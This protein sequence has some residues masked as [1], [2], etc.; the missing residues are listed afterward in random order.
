[1]SGLCARRVISVLWGLFLLINVDLELTVIMKVQVLKM[2]VK[3][4]RSDFTALLLVLS[5][6]NANQATNVQE[7]LL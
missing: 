3:N 6:K 4:V 5:R 1:M 2:I 7:Q